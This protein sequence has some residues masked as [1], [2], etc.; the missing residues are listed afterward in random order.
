MEWVDI[1]PSRSVLCGPYLVGSKNAVIAVA[2]TLTL[3]ILTSTNGS[4]SC[5]LLH[6]LLPLIGRDFVQSEAASQGKSR[7]TRGIPVG[8]PFPVS[9]GG[10]ESMRWQSQNYKYEPN[11]P[12]AYLKI[13]I[14][15]CSS[16]ELSIKM[17]PKSHC[18]WK[19]NL[20][21][22]PEVKGCSEILIG[23]QSESVWNSVWEV[24][25]SISCSQ[26]ER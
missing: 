17:V 5:I 16:R 14:V 15:P 13:H 7:P 26:I 10:A 11:E 4:Y 21:F 9:F 19:E 22:S 6:D 12:K 8:F 18:K 1:D 2:M 25:L 3:P 20:T 24:V 23:E